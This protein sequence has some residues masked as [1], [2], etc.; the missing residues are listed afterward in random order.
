MIVN[1][2][3]GIC[4]YCITYLHTCKSKLNTCKNKLEMAPE[5]ALNIILRFRNT[6]YSCVSDVRHYRKSLFFPYRGKTSVNMNCGCPHSLKSKKQNCILYVHHSLRILFSLDL[7]FWSFSRVF[8]I[9]EFRVGSLAVNC[10]DHYK[11]NL[12]LFFRE[13]EFDDYFED[14]FL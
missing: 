3:D 11:S 12:F 9:L 4:I 1:K 7:L 5:L 8:I 10:K 2:L 14:M 13:E 6:S